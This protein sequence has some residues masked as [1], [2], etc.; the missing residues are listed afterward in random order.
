[1]T[2]KEYLNQ[3]GIEFKEVGGELIAH[4]LFSG[5]DDESRRNEAHLYFDAETGQYDCK[6]CGAKGNILTL[7]RHFGDKDAN[8]TPPTTKYPKFS[9]SLVEQCHQRLPERVRS[10]L[11]DRGIINDT[12]NDYKLGYGQFYGKNWITIPIK[13]RD[14]KYAFF[15]LRQD[16]SEGSNKITFPKGSEAEIYDWETLKQNEDLIVICEGELDRLL[17]ISKGVPAITST[18][19]AM[20]FKA[21][22]R[23]DVSK[24]KKIYICFDND[25]AGRVGAKRIAELIKTPN[26][27]VYIVG[28]PQEVG[29]AG[30]ITDYFIKLKGNLDDLFSKYAKEFPEKIDVSKFE[31]LTSQ[32]LSEILGLTIKRDEENKIVTFLCQLSAYSEDAQFNI[33]YNAPSSTGK[34]FIPTEIAKL[35]PE[36]DVME[37]AYCSPT[38]FFHDIGEYN[39]EQEGYVVDLS[40]KIL[41]FLDQPHNDL[42]ARLRP[43]LSHDKKEINI[44]ITDKT[45]KFG[46]K[47]KNVLLKGYPSVI[48]CTAGLRIDEQE[49]T[50]F[51]LLSPQISQDKIR[52]S[53]L[54]IIKK[55]IDSESYKKWLQENPERALLQE[56]IKAIKEEHIKDIK[57]VDNKTLEEKFIQSGIFL[58]PRQ[59][60]DIKRLISVIK[61]FALLNLW[62]RERKDSIITANEED[63]EEAFKIWDKIYISQQYNLPPYIYELY[64]D[65]IVPLWQEREVVSILDD[66]KVSITRQDIIKQ[67]YRIDGSMLDSIKLRQQILPMLETAGLIMQEPDKNDKRKM[68]IFPAQDLPKENSESGGSVNSKGEQDDNL[69]ET[70]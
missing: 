68:L 39:Q 44:K 48:F 61:S 38:A 40:H 37:L 26:N 50:R 4:C 30:D 12:I 65:V 47:T 46:L 25:R 19:G 41:I 24:C 35:F 16:P 51:L 15:K 60:R 66:E 5:C 64:Q 11:N 67:K 8:Y 18:H 17:L 7:M 69:G 3:K 31:P 56:R 28:L 62:W 42:L 63:I 1:M 22:W 43:L 45:Q 6:K 58:K 32:A 54:E 33:S 52:E 13:N 59:Q 9:D 23:K 21:D 53:I 2:I 49:A 55:E 57:M 14:E 29:E 36:E 70:T 27:E 20:T 10:Y 34:S